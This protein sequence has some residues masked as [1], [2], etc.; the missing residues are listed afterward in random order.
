M[1][2]NNK[3]NCTNNSQWITFTYSQ[4]FSTASV[5]TYLKIVLL[6]LQFLVLTLV[7][8]IQR[9]KLD[10]YVVFYQWLCNYQRV[11]SFKYA[12]DNLLMPNLKRGMK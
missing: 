4:A 10:R 6:I 9:N 7:S 1:K 12:I 11:L 3:I 2:I 8:F 5:Y